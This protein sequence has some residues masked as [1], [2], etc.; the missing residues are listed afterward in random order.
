MPRSSYN[1]STECANACNMLTIKYKWNITVAA[2]RKDFVSF[3]D[4]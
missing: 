1:S 4:D 3:P 2:A